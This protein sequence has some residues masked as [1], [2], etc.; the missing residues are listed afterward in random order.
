MAALSRTER[1]STC[2]WAKP[3]HTSPVSG[4]VGVRPRVGL[5]PN[6]PQHDAGMRIE[7]PPPPPPARG[8]MHAATA[9]GEPPLE[10]PGGRPRSHGLRVGPATAGSVNGTRPNSGVF[11]LPRMT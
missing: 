10:P 4:P 3:R 2:S 7:P 5:S 9:A 8:T 11:V 1:V 6:T